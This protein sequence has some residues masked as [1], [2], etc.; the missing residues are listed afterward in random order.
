MFENKTE[1]EAREEIL[2][3]VGEYCDTFHNKKK[4]LR[5]GTGSLMHPAYTTGKRW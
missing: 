4:R 3:L 1:N 5:P 2:K